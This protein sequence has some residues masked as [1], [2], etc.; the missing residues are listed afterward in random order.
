MATNTLPSPCSKSNLTDLLGA[1]RAAHDAF[2]EADQASV[3]RY[4]AALHAVRDA[5]PTDPA[6]LAAQLRWIV[7]EQ[8]DLFQP[9]LGAILEHV[10]RLV[11]DPHIGWWAEVKELRDALALEPVN[12]D[13][14]ARR[15]YE[16][17]EM[18][19]TTAPRTPEG[20][21]VVCATLLLWQSDGTT[22]FEIDQD[23][24]ATIARYILAATPAAVL[25]R[26]G[27]EGVA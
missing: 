9:P 5:R 19:A 15:E 20:L 24:G 13:D 12:E 2:A 26:A 4:H 17:E 3:E 22:L 25:A 8:D 10:A 7:A 18:I 23:A 27:V 11:V 14:L 16:V 21:A 1:Y 6:E